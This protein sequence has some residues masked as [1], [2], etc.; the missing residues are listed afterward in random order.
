MAEGYNIKISIIP[1]N[2][3]ARYPHSRPRNWCKKT[4]CSQDLNTI[5]PDDLKETVD[6]KVVGCRTPCSDFVN[7]FFC[8]RN[9]FGSLETCLPSNYTTVFKKACPDSQSY[10]H[11]SNAI[12]N[13]FSNRYEIQFC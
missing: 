7:N 4:F 2:P 13:C 9:E 6:G 10:S 1:R 11:D 12:F 3:T 5:C 8:C